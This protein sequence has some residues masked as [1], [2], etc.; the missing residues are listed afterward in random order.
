MFD[1]GRSRSAIRAVCLAAAA[2]AVCGHPAVARG[3]NPV[4]VQN[5]AGFEGL[6]EPTVVYFPDTNTFQND[7]TS[8]Q[9]HVDE[10][11]TLFRDTVRN[12]YLTLGW[13]DGD[14][15]SAGNTDRQ[16]SEPKGIVGLGHQQVEQTFEYSFDFR[17]NPG[18]LP[19]SNFCHV[20]QLKATNGD[21]SPPLVTISL[22][23]SGSSIQGRVDCFTDGTN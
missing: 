18:F 19:T 20:F 14:G 22:Y 21:S 1:K 6:E 7:P 23:K 4:V 16:R 5:E 3:A 9:N 17:T 12:N 15:A 8:L 11:G 2:A 13:W 10:G